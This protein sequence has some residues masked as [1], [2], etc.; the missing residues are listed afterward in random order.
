M[1]VSAM[2]GLHFTF[3]LLGTVSLFIQIFTKAVKKGLMNEFNQALIQMYR[4]VFFGLQTP[5]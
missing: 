2:K 3:A 1:R 5:L 4:I